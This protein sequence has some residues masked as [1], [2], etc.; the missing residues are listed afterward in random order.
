MHHRHAST[1]DYDTLWCDCYQLPH[2][3]IACIQMTWLRE[4]E[5]EALGKCNN[6]A[7][8]CSMWTTPTTHTMTPYYSRTLG[9][10]PCG[11]EP[12]LAVNNY[13]MH[14]LYSV[15]RLPS[16]CIQLDIDSGPAAYKDR[17]P[18]MGRTYTW[19]SNRTLE[20]IARE[21]FV[22]YRP[23]P[24]LIFTHQFKDGEICVP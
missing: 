12:F 5:A 19:S 16:A 17:S 18:R 23:I 20:K 7:A 14:L 13:D 3:H 15:R 24:R 9:G 6:I 22:I 8:R 21:A 4:T 11:V 1:N 10:K 2:I